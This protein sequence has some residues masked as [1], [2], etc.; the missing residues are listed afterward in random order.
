MLKSQSAKVRHAG[1]YIGPSGFWSPSQN[2]RW[3]RTL[4]LSDAVT[5]TM[6]ST[7]E[8]ERSC[9]TRDSLEDCA[10]D[11]W[12]RFLSLALPPDTT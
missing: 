1:G 4:S 10:A 2:R 6:E 3:V 12:K 7:W 8:L 5:Y 11:R 9:I